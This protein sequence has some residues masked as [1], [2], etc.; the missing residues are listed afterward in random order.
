MTEPG[1]AALR[2]VVRGRVQGI[3]FR[4]YV[5]TRARFLGLSGYVRNPAHGRSPGGVA[6]PGSRRR[7]RD[8]VGRCH[9]L[10]PRLRGGVLTTMK[11]RTLVRGSE[12]N[13][14]D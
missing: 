9:R 14:A 10:L 1:L 3:G 6:A 11:P 2:A 7:R 13:P 8:W 12:I 4:D 5:Y